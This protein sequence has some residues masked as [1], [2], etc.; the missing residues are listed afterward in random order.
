[1]NA[2]KT[3][4]KLVSLVFAALI[5]AVLALG[6]TGQAQAAAITIERPLPPLPGGDINQLMQ[7]L[8][9]E[10]N[11]AVESQLQAELQEMQQ[12][13]RQIQQITEQISAWRA[14]NPGQEPTPEIQALIAQLEQLQSRSQMDLIQLQSLISNHNQSLDLLSNLLSQ[15]Q[16]SIQ[17]IIS[18]LR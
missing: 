6:G 10:R 18:N 15:Q 12:R 11:A 9:Q 8:M 7:R 5:V 1:M 3:S 17:T 13:N 2:M 14:M 4:H 16:Q